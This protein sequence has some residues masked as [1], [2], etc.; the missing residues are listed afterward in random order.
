MLIDVNGT[1][2]TALLKKLLSKSFSTSKDLGL[3]KKI[4]GMKISCDRSKKLL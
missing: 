1:K 2:R 4:V 3:A